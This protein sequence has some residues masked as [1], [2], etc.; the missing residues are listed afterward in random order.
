MSDST[1]RRSNDEGREIK[2]P[3]EVGMAYRKKQEILFAVDIDRLVDF[4]GAVLVIT[5][6]TRGKY[7]I[8]RNLSV[9]SLAEAWS[10]TVEDLDLLVKKFLS[11]P[12]P[13]GIRRDSW[14]KGEYRPRVGKYVGPEYE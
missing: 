4:S 14:A 11:P 13:E 9:R 1:K 8:D 3:F 2:R 6:D 5:D 7:T 10:M 12:R